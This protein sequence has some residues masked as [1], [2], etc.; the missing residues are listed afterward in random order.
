MQSTAKPCSQIQTLQ[1]VY[2]VLVLQP[3]RVLESTETSTEA[4]ALLFCI[5]C[6]FANK[7][8]SKEI[9]QKTL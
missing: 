1:R 6:C 9:R 3:G 4:K 5:Y 8:D 2:Y 7:R